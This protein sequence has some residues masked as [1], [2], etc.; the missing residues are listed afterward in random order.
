MFT[1]MQESDTASTKLDRRQMLFGDNAVPLA[2]RRVL[3]FLIVSLIGVL[4]SS[5]PGVGL[6]AAQETEAT[7]VAPA[8]EHVQSQ[9]SSGIS[10]LDNGDTT[11]FTVTLTMSDGGPV[12][13]D[14][15]ICIETMI[16][17]SEYDDACSDPG[18]TVLSVAL[19][20]SYHKVNVTGPSIIAEEVSYRPSSQPSY[21]YDFT[22][23]RRPQ[24]TINFEFLTPNGDPLPDGGFI[25]IYFAGSF[26]P[27]IYPIEGSTL[28]VTGNQGTIEVIVAV[29]GHAHFWDYYFF[30]N[31]SGPHTIQV[32]LTPLEV[33]P[34]IDLTITHSGSTPL[35]PGDTVNVTVHAGGSLTEEVVKSA[36]IRGSVSGNATIVD[37]PTC[38]VFSGAQASSC[39]VDGNGEMSVAIAPEYSDGWIFEAEMDFELQADDI[40]Q[41]TIEI[42]FCSYD[43]SMNYAQFCETVTLAIQVPEPE[44]SP[45]PSPTSIPTSEPT[46]VPTSE[47]TVTP[48]SPADTTPAAEA[49]PTLTATTQPSSPETPGQDPVD[50][51][52]LPSTGHGIARASLWVTACVL[53]AAGLLGVA[54]V[55]RLKGSQPGR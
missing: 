2:Q 52:S 8:P 46:S 17:S 55:R 30:L 12:P 41:G 28:Q 44:S 48:T 49:T 24:Q 5:L 36:V 40:D 9:E 3:R 43:S 34:V 21:H 18:D 47:P 15:V 31:P 38:E 51:S 19:P 20:G 50:V 27:A 4:S 7:P 39:D 16:T 1:S 23:T 11:S 32:H 26:E 33:Q 10:I 35:L 37:G 45:T 22:L 14:V 6:T 42:E 53:T 13:E 29:P 54:A 25:T